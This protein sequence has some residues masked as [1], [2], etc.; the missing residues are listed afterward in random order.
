MSIF[1]VDWSFLHHY[2][3]VN[4]CF[5]AILNDFIFIFFMLIVNNDIA[6]IVDRV[7]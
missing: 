7:L 1:L 3:S 6:Y 4:N 5:R 2:A